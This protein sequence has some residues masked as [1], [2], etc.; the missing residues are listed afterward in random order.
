MTNV[1]S[2]SVRNVIGKMKKWGW[3]CAVVNLMDAHHCTDPYKYLSILLV[4]LSTMIHLNAPAIHILSKI[5]LLSKYGELDFKLDFYTDVLDLEYLLER[6]PLGDPF[7]DKF[8][9]L[10]ES[11]IE[12]LQDYNMVSFE[13]LDIMEKSSVEKV[14]R[15]VDSANGFLYSSLPKDTNLLESVFDF[16]VKSS[17][18]HHFESPQDDAP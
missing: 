16:G 4:S 7:S 6:F 9:G 17:L 1:Y 8:R 12:T 11:L 15:V 18:V 13:T 10:T 5:D 3:N 14:A 2:R